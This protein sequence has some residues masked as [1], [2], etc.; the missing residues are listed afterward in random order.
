[1]TDTGRCSHESSDDS[2]FVS[3]YPHHRLKMG[4]QNVHRIVPKCARQDLEQLTTVGRIGIPGGVLY[5]ERTMLTGSHALSRSA[6]APMGRR[7]DME[8]FETRP[9]P[10]SRPQLEWIRQPCRALRP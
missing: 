9:A 2:I 8:P 1:M 4:V 7:A 10:R 5:H 3:N 6:D